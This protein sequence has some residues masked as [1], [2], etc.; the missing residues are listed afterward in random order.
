MNSLSEFFHLE[1]ALPQLE[2]ALS[3]STEACKVLAWLG[4]SIVDFTAAMAV[5]A[6]A[7]PGSSREFLHQSR[8]R[9]TQ[10]RAMSYFLMHGTDAIERSISPR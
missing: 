3:Y 4:D 7:R 5:V 9:Y 10:N 1:R 8:E 6:A 2:V